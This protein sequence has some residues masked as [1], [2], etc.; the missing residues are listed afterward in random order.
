VS[1]DAFWDTAMLLSARPAGERSQM[2]QIPQRI[3]TAGWVAA[4]IGG[5]AV[6]AACINLLSYAVNPESIKPP[7]NASSGAIGDFIF[8]HSLILIVIHAVISAL[9]LASGVELSQGKEAGRRRLAMTLWAAI[10]LVVVVAVGMLSG[11]LAMSTPPPEVTALIGLKGRVLRAML[12][13]GGVL[14]MGMTLSI[15][16]LLYLAIRWLNSPAVRAACR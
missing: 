14:A 3:R 4:A 1:T 6:I 11:F 7:P 9:V 13:V 10:L 2:S 15:A 16:A 8:T 12:L 5:I